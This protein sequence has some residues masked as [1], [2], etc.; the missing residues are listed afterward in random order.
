MLSII[1]AIGKNYEIGRKNQL[2]CHL[3]DD[4]KHFKRTTAGHAVLMGEN[5]WF[6][7]PKRPLPNRRNIVLTLDKGKSYEGAEM[8]YSIDEAMRLCPSEEEVFIMGGASVYRAAINLMDKLYITHVHTVVA[9]ADVFFP[10]IDSNLWEVE[11]ASPTRRDDGTGLE[12]E[13]VV[14]KRRLWN[15]TEKSLGAI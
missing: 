10:E 9:D 6:S 15:P 12:Y 5:T 8:A 1:V 11:A 14:Y 4:L 3:P 13:F 2:L 7:L